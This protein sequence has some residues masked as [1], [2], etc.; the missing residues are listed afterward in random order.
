MANSLDNYLGAVI[1][2]IYA[3]ALEYERKYN[4][5]SLTNDAQLTIISNYFIN[6]I[7]IGED[8]TAKIFIKK[9][10]ESY[11]TWFYLQTGVMPNQERNNYILEMPENERILNFKQLKEKRN[12][13]EEVLNILSKGKMFSK[14]LLG[15]KLNSSSVLTKL[16]P[17]ALF[18]H[19]RPEAAFKMGIEIGALTH[20]DVNAQVASG[21]Y[22]YLL[23]S[24]LNDIS[25]T[26]S[27]KG[28][29]NEIKVFADGYD[30]FMTIQKLSDILEGNKSLAEAFN[31]FDHSA[32]ASDSLALAYYCY[33][34]NKNNPEKALAMAYKTKDPINISI[35]TGTFL[36]AHN[37]LSAFDEEAINKIDLVEETINI[38]QGLYQWIQNLED[39]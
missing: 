12:V 38:V 3:G 5:L 9:V 13:D 15:N 28:V 14:N 20:G 2:G 27:L 36:G 29:I 16:A 39:E 6:N 37:G 34:V 1:G 23:A 10:F 25:P 18:F 8:L 26:I 32:N 31:S 33:S 21:T 17:V 35:L 30:C 4:K 24:I 7:F 22:I 11:L 19:K